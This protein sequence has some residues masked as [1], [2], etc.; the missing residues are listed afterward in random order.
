MIVRAHGSRPSAFAVFRRRNFTLL[1]IAQFISTMG[2]GLTAI[3][4]SILV[5]RVT[6][7]ALSVGIM[8]L[9]TAL[10]DGAGLFWAGKKGTS[11]FDQTQVAAFEQLAARVAASLHAPE[12]REVRLGRLARL[13]AVERPLRERLDDVVERGFP[14]HRA[15]GEPGGEGEVAGIELEPLRLAPQGAIGPR[16][17]L[18]DAA[19]DGVCGA[20]GG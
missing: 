14:L 2:S 19:E 20:A 3:A 16:V 15:V 13:E 17:V 18:E 8:L 6:G 9:V 1:W 12:P 7:S 10:P 5:Y 11:K 4:A